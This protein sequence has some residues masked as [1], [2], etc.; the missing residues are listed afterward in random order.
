MR[1]QRIKLLAN[2][3][4]ELLFYLRISYLTSFYFLV[5]TG[6]SKKKL[7]RTPY[8]HEIMSIIEKRYRLSDL[9]NQRSNQRDQLF[10]YLE[11]VLLEEYFQATTSRRIGML[12]SI[13]NSAAI[14]QLYIVRL[15]LPLASETRKFAENSRPK[16]RQRKFCS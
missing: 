11:L 16:R 8:A 14:D 12:Y 6:L 10:D 15:S 7:L 5:V 9:T 3:H 4:K 2:I 1:I 13:D